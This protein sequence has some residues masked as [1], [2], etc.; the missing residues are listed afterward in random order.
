MNTILDRELRIRL[1]RERA[2][3]RLDLFTGRSQENVTPH[4]R[5]YYVCAHCD[6]QTS[7]YGEDPTPGWRT[8]LFSG[9]EAVH[10]C[11]MCAYEWDLANGGPLQ[12]C[13]QRVAGVL[14]TPTEASSFKTP[15]VA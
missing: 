5:G 11:P 9:C 7:C 8:I 4:P 2:E 15:Q 6:A 1:Y 14:T 10:E 12:V 13:G 3:L